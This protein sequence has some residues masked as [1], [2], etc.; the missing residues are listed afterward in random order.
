M[1]SRPHT[2]RFRAR[3]ADFARASEDWRHALAA[4]GVHGRARSHAE[5]AFEEVVSN[6]IRHGAAEHGPPHIAVSLA[7]AP[8]AIVLTFDDDGQAFDPL[9]RPSPTLPATL[10]EAPIGGLGILLLRKSSTRLEYE[11]TSDRKNRLTVTIAIA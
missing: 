7:C 4:C 6:V 3:L 8:D 2:L 5:L 10:D 1:E 9:T 11:R